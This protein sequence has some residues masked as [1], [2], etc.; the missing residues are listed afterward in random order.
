M[1]LQL[2]QKCKDKLS[3]ELTIFDVSEL[4]GISKATARQLFCR[5]D[6][7]SYWS[8]KKLVVKTNDLIDYFSIR[9]TKMVKENNKSGKG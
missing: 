1:S 6:F 9:R 3:K 8:P 2:L 7:P 5:D 4:M